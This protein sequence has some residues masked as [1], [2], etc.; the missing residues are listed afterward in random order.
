MKFDGSSEEKMVALEGEMR[1]LALSVASKDSLKPITN[2]QLSISHNK[3]V[4][5]SD[6]A[7][8]TQND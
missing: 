1:Y 3:V 2:Q 6:S 7:P 4:Q 8:I 5:T